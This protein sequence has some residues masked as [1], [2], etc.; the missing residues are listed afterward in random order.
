MCGAIILAAEGYNS[1]IVSISTRQPLG[2]SFTATQLLAGQ[3]VKYSLYTSLKSAKSA[4]SARKHTVFTTLS[5]EEPAASRRAFTFLQ[6]C[7]V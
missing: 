2:I 6:T 1:A 3:E 4:M 5:R 7:S